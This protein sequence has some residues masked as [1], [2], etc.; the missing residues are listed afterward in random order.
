MPLTPAELEPLLR[1][2]LV[3]G[4]GPQRLAQLLER[5]GSAEGVLSAGRAALRAMP[6][7]GDELVPRL[8]AAGGREGAEGIRRAMEVLGALGAVAVT[9]TD[10]AFPAC[11]RDLRDPP[12]L[13]FATGDLALLNR[14]GVAVVG[15]RS[16]SG[17]G[18]RAAAALSRDL[19]LA[20]Y[21]IVSGMARGVDAEAHAAALEAG[22][23]TVG[24]LGNGIEQVYPPENGRLFARVR[25]RGLLLTEYPPGEMP[26]AGNFPRRNRLITALSEAVLIV[27][28]GLRS[29][30]QHSVTYALEQGKEVMAVPGPIDSPMSAGTNQLIRD[31]ATAVT[32]ARDVV[33]E[34][35]GVG[36]A[37]TA[38]ITPENPK[39]EASPT[40]PLPL[41]TADEAGLLAALSSE[42]M[43]VDDLA[44]TL[45]LPAGRALSQLLELELRGLV[46][47]L[48]GKRYRSVSGVAAY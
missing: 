14:Q 45:G 16:P 34:L 48:P 31:G 3:Q 21:V 26:R 7:I 17:Y 5:F 33:E 30:A 41:L 11:L 6:G 39:G 28:M 23:R 10:P 32:C 20:G 40:L 2:S 43:H 46:E 22:G 24:V 35:R 27:E 13:L 44:S 15:T 9:A 37:G 36:H 38:G 19:A 25:E 1:L 4:V 8:V 47:A 42:A 12:Y 29:G 18:R